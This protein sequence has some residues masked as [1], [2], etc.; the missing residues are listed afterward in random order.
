MLYAAAAGVGLIDA[1]ANAVLTATIGVDPAMVSLEIPEDAAVRAPASRVRFGVRPPPPLSALRPGEIAVWIA[2]VDEPGLLRRVGR[3]MR[4]VPGQE[5]PV[6]VSW[7]EPVSTRSAS[8]VEDGPVPVIG[9]GITLS[10]GDLAPGEYT[11]E[12]AVARPDTDPVRGQRRF[13]VAPPPG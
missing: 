1:E 5:S 6:G 3:T 2:K 13:R 11:M 9:R 8:L 7:R 12:V 10:L 4:I